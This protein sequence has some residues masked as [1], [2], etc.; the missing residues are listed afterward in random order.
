VL[1]NVRGDFVGDS[2]VP[3]DTRPVCS[4]TA[5]LIFRSA[6]VAGRSNEW[7]IVDF[8]NLHSELRVGLADG[9]GFDVLESDASGNHCFRF[10]SGFVERDFGG[11]CV[12]D[13][14]VVFLYRGSATTSLLLKS[15]TA[16]GSRQRMAGEGTSNPGSKYAKRI[17]T[18]AKDIRRSAD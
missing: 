12:V 6:S 17:S 2:A 11:A 9:L 4:R 13:F 5:E 14:H 7:L 3:E 1:R 10:G 16:L 18:S 15:V 8:P